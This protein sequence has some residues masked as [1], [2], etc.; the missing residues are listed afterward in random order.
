M[1]VQKKEKGGVMWLTAGLFEFRRK[2]RGL[3]RKDP[4]PMCVGDEDAKYSLLKC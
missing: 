3:E 1:V 4:L 2:N